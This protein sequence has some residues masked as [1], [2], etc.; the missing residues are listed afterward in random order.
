M[1]WVGSTLWEH[2][3]LRQSHAFTDHGAIVLEK[4]LATREPSSVDRL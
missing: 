2:R 1:T 3:D 4:A